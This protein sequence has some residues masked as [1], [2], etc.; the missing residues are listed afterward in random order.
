MKLSNPSPGYINFNS[1]VFFVF[2]MVTEITF[3]F[4]TLWNRFLQNHS[5]YFL[6]CYL[7]PHFASFLRHFGISALIGTNSHS[8][9]SLS[10]KSAVWLWMG[11]CG[12]H[13]DTVQEVRVH[14]VWRSARHC[15]PFTS[16]DT[17]TLPLMLTKHADMRWGNLISECTFIRKTSLLW[18]GVRIRNL[19]FLDLTHTDTHSHAR[20]M[21]LERTESVF[22][23]CDSYMALCNWIVQFS[24]SAPVCG[25]GR[26]CLTTLTH[27]QLKRQGECIRV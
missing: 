16:P 18:C 23:V 17:R 12:S 22:L 15:L 4:F 2:E 11:L 19:F 20:L 7:C 3:L 21:C 10:V 5:V 6:F 13:S 9:T 24:T 26:T 1:H 25:L 27:T 14:S 8:C